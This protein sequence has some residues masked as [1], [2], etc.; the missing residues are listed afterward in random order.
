MR[1]STGPRRLFA[2]YGD[3]K[4]AAQAVRPRCELPVGARKCRCEA[5]LPWCIDGAEAT[6]VGAEHSIRSAKPFIGIAEL[7]R[8]PI[9]PQRGGCSEQR[10]RP[11]R[12]RAYQSG[13][14]KWLGCRWPYSLA[15]V[16]LRSP[17]GAVVLML[18]R[19]KRR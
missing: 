8:L 16:Q 17:L 1:S 18:L 9:V 6:T 5:H 10:V 14:I 13:R 7:R 3:D 19:A 12:L 15:S 4:C 11:D 2:Y